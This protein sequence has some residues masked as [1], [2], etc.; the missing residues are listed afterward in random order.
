MRSLDNL[1][2]AR[3]CECSHTR[4]NRF[5]CLPS[6]L[7]CTPRPYYFLRGPPRRYLPADF[8]P[9]NS[10]IALLSCSPQLPL[11]ILLLPNSRLQPPGLL[12]SSSTARSMIEGQ[13]GDHS[14]LTKI[15]KSILPLLQP[16][17]VS[18]SLKEA[19]LEFELLSP[20]APRVQTIPRFPGADGR[21]PT[22]EEENL[23]PS[24]LVKFK[25]VETDSVAFT[26]LAD[27]I[28]ERIEPLTGAATVL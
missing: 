17:F 11:S 18:S 19:N 2:G 9:E 21:T 16:A 1:C 25:P 20:A 22:L 8:T 5:R 10:S 4:A 14:S 13:M 6:S 15:R 24:A 12:P 3:A 26:G 23:V 7:L 28:L 27:E